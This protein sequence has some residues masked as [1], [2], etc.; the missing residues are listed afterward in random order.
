MR[1]S[2]SAVGGDKNSDGIQEVT[3][4]FRKMDMRTLFAGLPSGPNTVT[5]DITGSLVS[6]GQ[7]RATTQIIVKSNGTFLAAG[8]SPNPLN[9]QAK[10]TFLTTKPGAVR[11]QMFDPQGRLV[12]TI[13][14]GTTVQAGY[15]DFTIDGRS[16]T[17]SK[18]ASGVYFVKV[19]SQFDGTEV[20]SVT[21]LK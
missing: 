17:G 1:A 13:A 4:C 6:G 19:W 2:K 8:I 10:L 9:P 5:I 14:D 18:L 21:I 7:F 15:H 12:K 16:A 3:A 11:V 20:K